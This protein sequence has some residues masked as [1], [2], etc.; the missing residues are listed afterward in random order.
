M[1]HYPNH[2]HH[3]Q[4]LGAQLFLTGHTHGGQVCL[5]G[6]KPII[7]H[8]SL[9]YKHCRGIHKL[10]KT[11]LVVNHGLGFSGLPLRVM[12]PPE[13]IELTLTLAI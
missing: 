11:W 10:E 7:T 3:A 13:V 8:S 2:L 4:R 12:C 6:G 5:P 1:S 9:P